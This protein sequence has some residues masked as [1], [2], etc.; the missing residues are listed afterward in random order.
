MGEVAVMGGEDGIVGSICLKAE[1]VERGHW[2]PVTFLFFLANSLYY[3]WSKLRLQPKAIGGRVVI[4][5]HLFFPFFPFSLLG[6]I[7]PYLD[8][9]KNVS[10]RFEREPN[11][12]I[13]SRRRITTNTTD[14]AN[15]WLQGQQ[16]QQQQQEEEEEDIFLVQNVQWWYAFEWHSSW[17]R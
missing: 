9:L 8:Y 16:Q 14:T 10:R 6:E 1:E 17:W 12:K 13:Q 5:L 11:T 3:K 15:P 7:V 4:F 2:V